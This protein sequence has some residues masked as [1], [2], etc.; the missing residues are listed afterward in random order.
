MITS[1][2]RMFVFFLFHCV[3]YVDVEALSCWYYK[4]FI[5]KELK[6]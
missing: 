3:E 2:Q 5:A 6:R 4:N 1:I